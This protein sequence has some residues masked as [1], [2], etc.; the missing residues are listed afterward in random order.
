MAQCCLVKEHA[1]PESTARRL[2]TAARGLADLGHG[3]GG[4]LNAGFG[5]EHWHTCR[6]SRPRDAPLGTHSLTALPD[7]RSWLTFL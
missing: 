6:I 3:V 1:V 2:I 5:R 4:A 7:E